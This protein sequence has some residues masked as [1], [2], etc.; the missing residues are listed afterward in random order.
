M[1]NE[2]IEIEDN[3][4]KHKEFDRLH[5]LMLVHKEFPWIYNETVDF[6]G[7]VDNPH[8]FQFTHSFYQRYRWS[9]SNREKDIQDLQP[10]ITKIKPI[11][12]LRIKANLLTRTPNIVENE[13]HVDFGMTEERLKLWTTSILYMNSNNG[14]TLFEDGTKVESVANS[15]VTFPANMKHTGT[16]CTDEKVRVVI[17]FNYFK[18]EGPYYLWEEPSHIPKIKT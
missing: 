2:N 13:F 9:Y 16:T 1:A 5:Q 15:M 12:I 7:D 14:Y 8:K 17:N 6:V 4:I 10:I 18:D 3:F 11:S